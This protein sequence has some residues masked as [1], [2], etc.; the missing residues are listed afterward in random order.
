MNRYKHF[1]KDMQ[2]K[3]KN[4]KQNVTKKVKK[5]V[6][7]FDLILACFETSKRR[8]FKNEFQNF[9]KDLRNEY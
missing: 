2:K 4:L 6:E 8:D 5:Y 9:Q 7:R 1:Q 3:Y